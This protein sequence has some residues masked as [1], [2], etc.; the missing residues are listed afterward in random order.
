MLTDGQ[1]GVIVE[2]AA[3]HIAGL[4]R[5]ARD[6]LGAVDAVLVGC[7]R[8]KLKRPV[9]VT[10]IAWID[11]AEETAPLDREALA[12][13]RGAASITPYAAQLQPMMVI[14]QDGVGRLDRG[15][16]QEPSAG[17]LQ[18]LRREGI[19]ALAHGGQAEVRAVR[20]HRGEQRPV[21][22]GAT[23][24]IAAERLEGAGKAAPFVDV[25]QQIFNCVLAGGWN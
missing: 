6:D 22:I 4:T 20:D 14:D 1:L 11:A 7:V 5:R 25:L 21:Q 13:G 15:V 3:K 8:I 18:R 19:D 24:L 23:W 16:T 17:V 12:I 10:E 9:V 2:N